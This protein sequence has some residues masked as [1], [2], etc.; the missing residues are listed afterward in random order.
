MDIKAGIIGCGSIA[1]FRHAPEYRAN[2]YVSEIVFYDRNLERAEELATLFGGSVAKSVDKLLADPEIEVISDCSSNENHHLFSTKALKSGKHVLCEKPISLTIEHANQVVDAQKESGR[3]LMVD[4]N[5]R[6]T[7]A[8]QKAKEIIENKELGNVLTFQTTFGHQGPEYWGV[9]KTNSTWF[10]KKDRSGF[11]VVGDLGIHKL[12]LIHYLLDDQIE[13]VSAF[14]AAL[15]KVDENGEPIEVC[16]N[17]VCSLKTNQGRL[18]TASF[19]WTY[20]GQEDNS[21][22]IYCEKGILKIYHNSTYQLEVFT[23]DGEQINYKLESIQTND[24]QTNTGVIDAFIDCV[25]LDTEPIVSGQDAL[26][27]LKV[28]LGVMEAA[29]TNKVVTI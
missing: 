10:F 14:Q 5:Q 27:S 2:P 18:G 25:R 22:I 20:Y 1:K 13:Q 21:T 6:F 15:D 12:D 3:K 29:E 11:G 8:H 23:K 17:V 19:S 28:I 26:L 7:R 4:H 16:D 24:S 9:N